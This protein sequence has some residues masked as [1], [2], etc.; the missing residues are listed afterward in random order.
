MVEAVFIEMWLFCALLHT[1]PDIE[2]D[3]FLA[4]AEYLPPDFAIEL[5]EAYHL[6]EKTC[7]LL[8]HRQ[9]YHLLFGFIRSR[10]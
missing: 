6:T 9:E 5:L 3:Q 4:S 2:L 7:S 8:Y 10:Y 1:A